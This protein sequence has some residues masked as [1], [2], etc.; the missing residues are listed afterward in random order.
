MTE[1]GEHPA[2][3]FNPIVMEDG[4]VIHIQADEGVL[5]AG[6]QA[7]CQHSVWY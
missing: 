3:V 1:T 5:P 7:V 2:V 6:I 4:T